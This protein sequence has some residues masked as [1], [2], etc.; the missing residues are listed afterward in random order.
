MKKCLY[1][2]DKVMAIKIAYHI[3]IQHEKLPLVKFFGKHLY[4]WI[5]T[6]L[7]LLFADWFEQMNRQIDKHIFYFRPY[8]PFFQK[9][10]LLNIGREFLNFKL[11]CPSLTDF[12]V[13]IK[14]VDMDF[15]EKKR[16]YA[17][18]CK[19][20]TYA[21]RLPTICSNMHV[22]SIGDFSWC[23]RLSPR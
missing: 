21:N 1:F 22:W 7:S 3:W 4:Y 13:T 18:V 11:I 6:R 16:K 17:S 15:E 2:F 5:S 8:N 10:E 23:K 19:S 14:C 9:R 20:I 12:N